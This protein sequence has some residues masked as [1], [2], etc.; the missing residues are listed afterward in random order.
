MADISILT[1]GADPSAERISTTAIQQAIAKAQPGDSV[2]IP[3]GRYLT[4]AIFLKSNIT[5]HLAE[6]A[7][8]LGSQHLEDYPLI[9][10]RVAGIDMRWPAGMIN[11]INAQ[12]VSLTGTGSLDGQGRIWWQRFWGDDERGGMVGDYSASGDFIMH[13]G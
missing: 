9:D 5:L 13:R 7:V 6:G 4:G 1:F 2:V 12:N 11:V 10:T 8:L 3:A